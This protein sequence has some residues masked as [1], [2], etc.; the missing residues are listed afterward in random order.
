MALHLI[1]HAALVEGAC[2]MPASANSLLVPCPAVLDRRPFAAQ[3][4]HLPVPCGLLLVALL[5]SGNSVLPSAFLQGPVSS[6]GSL[7]MQPQG[8]SGVPGPFL[9]GSPFMGGL[10]PMHMSQLMMQQGQGPMMM[11]MQGSQP[12]S[13]QQAPA[14][15]QG[16]G[17]PHA[18]SAGSAQMEPPMSPGKRGSPQPQLVTGGLSRVHS[19]SVGHSSSPPPGASTR[20]LN[21]TAK[22]F[23]PGGGRGMPPSPQQAQQ[24]QHQAGPAAAAGG[25]PLQVRPGSA[26]SQ[27]GGSAH[28]LPARAALLAEA[29]VLRSS[30]SGEAAL[31][32]SAGQHPAPFSELQQLEVGSAACKIAYTFQ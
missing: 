3:P 8:P 25:G 26:G 13:Q 17:L 2:S 12:M 32:R 15:A 22:P 1:L 31:L 6:G 28:Q 16:Q 23:V 18:H 21:A 10:V 20:G 4:G 7:P 30:G 29:A 11:P 24:Q 9:M 5:H 19:G 27:L 14:P